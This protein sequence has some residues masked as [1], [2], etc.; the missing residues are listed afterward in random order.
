MTD[1][2]SASGWIGRGYRRKEDHRLMTGHGEYLADIAIPG[3]LHLA[4]VRSTHA[5]ARITNIDTAAALAMPG[6]VRV[7]TAAD[8]KGAM[9][10]FPQAVLVPNM[11]ARHPTFWPLAVDKVKFHGEPVAAVVAT[12]AYL[13][14]DAAEA[15]VI[16]YE[17]LTPVLDAESAFAAAAPKVHDDWPDNEIFAMT[18]TGG[19]TEEDRAN[20]AAEVERL[21][22]AGDV[23][24]RERFRVHRTGVT[25]LETRGAVAVWTEGYGLKAWITTQRPHIEQLALADLLGI[26]EAKIRVIAPRDQGGGFGVKAPIHREPV[27]VCHL[28]RELGRP[29]CWIETRAEHLMAVSQE[30]D[31]I[32]DIEVAADKEGRI[33]AVR[34]RGLG[35][36]CA[37]VYW[38]HLMPFLG[39][40]LLPN[41]YDLLT[42]DIS[43]RVAVTNKSCSSPARS[44][45]AFP[46][47]FALDRCIDMVAHRLGLEP[48]DVRRQNLIAKLPYTTCTGL[49]YDASDWL[50]T[51]DNLVSAVDLAGFRKTQLAAR[52]EGRFFGIGF[53][54]GAEVSGAPSEAYVQMANQPGY[55][56]ATVRL[57]PRGKALVFH[58]D[59]PSGQSHET[60]L[61][62][63]AAK[64][65]G[66]HPDDVFVTIG[67]TGTTPFGCGTNGSRQASYTVSGVAEACRVLKA[68]MDRFMIHD[69]ELSGATPGDFDYRD[70]EVIYRRDSNIRRTLAEQANRI[71]MAP[72]NM[73]E[74]EQ[75]GLEHTAYFEA[76]AAMWSFSAQAAIVEVDPATGQFRIERYVTSEDVGTVI[77]P[78]VVEGQVQGGVVQGISNA[79]FEEFAF[80]ENG[81]HLSADFENYQIARA[82]DVPDITVTHAGTPCLHNPLGT[83]GL[84]EGICAPVPGALG[85]AISDA[86]LVTELPLNAN[87]VY[88]LIQQAK[89]KAA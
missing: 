8:L 17:P 56:S 55:G 5:H 25:P 10:P 12:D 71:I 73:P 38:G 68:K 41:A 44:F 53:A 69:F 7:V 61:S 6:V 26:P 20:N 22:G 35:D 27:L 24:I 88:D 72:I 37:G 49:N 78:L 84:G 81:Q 34:D 80:D 3:M 11:L 14:E 58:G 40:A 67:D 13:A 70:G 39:A 75:A 65:F 79:C 45:G 83:R 28:A 4:F 57:D 2:E 74:G 23:V 36:G 63:V 50:K 46:T 48:A 43:V 19:A 18:L 30:R 51:W 62:Q 16:D 66:I 32:H 86:L 85:N 9:L 54:V 21:I 15:I 82:P 76:D 33:T 60:T 42:C 89:A 47:R 1:A 31:Q 87:R 52:E 77:N 59:A 64:E 29:V